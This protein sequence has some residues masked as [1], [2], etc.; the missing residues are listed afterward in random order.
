MERMNEEWMSSKV[1]EPL[2]FE[3]VRE[4]GMSKGG[5]THQSL[6]GMEGMYILFGES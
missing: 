6:I 4:R 2:E 1:N 3:W 5:Y